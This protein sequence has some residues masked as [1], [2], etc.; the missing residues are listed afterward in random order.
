ML[1]IKSTVEPLLSLCQ[2]C[3][4]R[5]RTN[6]INGFLILELYHCK[7]SKNTPENAMK[8]PSQMITENN[9]VSEMFGDVPSGSHKSTIFQS[10]SI[11]L[12]LTKSFEIN[13][14]IIKKIKGQGRIYCSSDSVVSEDRNDTNIYQTNFLNTQTHSG[15]LL[16]H[17]LLL[18][19]AWNCR[20][21]HQNP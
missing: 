20:N 13:R 12:R 5:N 8:I 4:A 7:L 6:S 1:Y 11:S 3:A 10:A 18:K 21:F 15:L 17:V 2:S 16:P 19:H 9:I 14:S